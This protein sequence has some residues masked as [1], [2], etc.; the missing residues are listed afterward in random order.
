MERAEPNNA[1]A[2]SIQ[3]KETSM[4][5]QKRSKR[6]M[7]TVLDFSRIKGAYILP[8]ELCAKEVDDCQDQQPIAKSSSA[9]EERQ[10]VAGPYLAKGEHQDDDAR[11]LGQEEKELESCQNAEQYI[12][13]VTK[14]PCFS[15]IFEKVHVTS[16]L[17]ILQ[18]GHRFIIN[19]SFSKIHIR[20]LER[21]IE[22]GDLL[23]SN[24]IIT[25]H[26][27]Q[28]IMPSRETDIANLFQLKF[29]PLIYSNFI[30]TW[31]AFVLLC[32]IH[33]WSK[34]RHNR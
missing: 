9:Y 32:S 21:P 7:T 30:S 24:H 4:V 29:S 22:K 23:A 26:I 33:T 5:E 34:M 19:I 28:Y 20:N 16:I 27:G 18:S 25:E 12:V 13:P 14:P 3:L 10:H 17:A 1:C 6:N 8:Y 31:V 2:E 11:D 15:N